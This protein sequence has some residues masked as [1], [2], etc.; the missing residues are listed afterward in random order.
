MSSSN[1]VRLSGLAAVLGSV[2]FLVA[3]LLSFATETEDLRRGEWATTTPFLLTWSLFL[4]GGVLLL[5]GLV[6]LYVRQ[7]EAAGIYG[8]L[9]FVA[10]FLGTAL[11]VG[12]IWSQLFIV[13]DLGAE[14]PMANPA[15][16]PRVA[17]QPVGAFGFSQS[18]FVCF[19]LGWGLF[20][21][22]TL[23]ARV[24]PRAAAIALV[25][26]AF[27]AYL[28]VPLSGIVLDAAVAWLGFILFTG[29]GET[30]PQ[31]SRVS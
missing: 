5:I 20:G 19:P 30:A 9:G 17:D 12:A 15:R 22:T 18:F 8:L 11:A 24:Y 31:P 1:L 29:R 14:P 28:P 10:A 4:F 6:G 2:F 23:T 26:G 7:S 25:V 21:A 13:P 27:L 16:V 3:E